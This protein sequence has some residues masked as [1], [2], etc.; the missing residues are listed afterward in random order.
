MRP[1][2]H[3]MQAV[4]PFCGACHDAVTAAPSNTDRYYPED[5]DV[6]MCIDCGRFAIYDSRLELR[7]PTRQEQR[8]LDR[9]K[10]YRGMV[11]AWKTIR[12]K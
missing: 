3:D 11:T 9:D 2:I 5:G 7:K 1:P 12:R 8:E 4:C 6:S 10:R